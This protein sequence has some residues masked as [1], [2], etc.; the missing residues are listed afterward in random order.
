MPSGLPMKFHYT[1]D[2]MICGRHR[3][4][5]LLLSF[6]K[7]LQNKFHRTLV[8]VEICYTIGQISYIMFF[9]FFRDIQNK[10]PRTLFSKQNF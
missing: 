7:I 4:L 10:I 6:Q 3:L 2:S 5:P 9:L 8:Q 1:D